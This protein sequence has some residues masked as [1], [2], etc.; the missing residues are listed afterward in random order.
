MSLNDCVKLNHN[1]CFLSIRTYQSPA[2]VRKYKGG[3]V[4]SNDEAPRTHNP[5]LTFFVVV[6]F[7][8]YTT[9]NIML[10]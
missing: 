4:T 8:Y 2:V 1:G 10:Y 9:D 5:K 6:I 3:I 7:I